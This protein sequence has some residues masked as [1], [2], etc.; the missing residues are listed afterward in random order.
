MDG[1]VARNSRN[2]TIKTRM[3]QNAGIDVNLPLW[4][5]RR[6]YSLPILTGSGGLYSEPEEV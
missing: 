6:R 4:E 2:R 1:Q 3:R 5:G